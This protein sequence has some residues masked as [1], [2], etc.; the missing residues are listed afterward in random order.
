M[1]TK[2]K[3]RELKGRKKGRNILL[4][5]VMK[6][7]HSNKKCSYKK[8][9]TIESINSA[10]R[11]NEV[12]YHTHQIRYCQL[13]SIWKETSL[14]IH[15]ARQ[16]HQEL[17]HLQSSLH[18]HQPR[19]RMCPNIS[20][21]FLLVTLR[22]EELSRCDDQ[23]FSASARS[24]PTWIKPGTVQPAPCCQKLDF[25]SLGAISWQYTTPCI[26]LFKLKRFD[27]SR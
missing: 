5:V 15:W 8:E 9:L 6:R 12:K 19:P 3:E 10:I 14:K 26:C 18:L 4:G 22:L 21:S 11:L 1:S 25:L 20:Q 16:K 24:P 2:N 23:H 27:Q 17:E 7:W 13:R